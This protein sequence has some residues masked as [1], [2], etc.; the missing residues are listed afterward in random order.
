MPSTTFFNKTIWLLFMLEKDY[1]MTR[2]L[3]HYIKF[4]TL[5]LLLLLL[6]GLERGRGL[7]WLALGRDYFILPPFFHC[8]LLYREGCL[9][10]K[11]SIVQPSCR[12]SH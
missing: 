4:L 8:P 10:K 11:H 6:P 1:S 7:T 12:W 9:K 2:L 3:N 5:L